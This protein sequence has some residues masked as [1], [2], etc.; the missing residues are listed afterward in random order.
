MKSL[1]RSLMVITATCALSISTIS[2]S[3]ITRTYHFP[4][5]Q[6][7]TIQ[8][9]LYWELDTHCSISSDENDNTLVGRMV[10]KKG[11]INGTPLEEGHDITVTVHPDD[12]LHLE[13]DYKAIVQITN[14]GQSTVSAK[15]RI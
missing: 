2:F 4:P 8:N 15:C 6:P 13:A 9:P 11:K 10:R 3:A 14:Y 7:V 1:R 5:N 12:D